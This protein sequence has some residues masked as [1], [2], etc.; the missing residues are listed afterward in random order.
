MVYSLAEVN[1]SYKFIE[2]NP[3]TGVLRVSSDPFIKYSING[4]WIER[5]TVFASSPFDMQSAKK[6]SS[7][8][9]IEVLKITSRC[10][11]LQLIDWGKLPR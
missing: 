8:I 11:G 6:S 1:S 4:S 2:I 9:Y 3:I 7:I 10:N 5:L